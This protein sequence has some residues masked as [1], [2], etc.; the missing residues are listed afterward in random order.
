[1]LAGVL[2]DV[3]QL[4]PARSAAE[5]AVRAA[6]D[7]SAHI[8][9]LDVLI[10]VLLML[11]ELGAARARLE[12]LRQAPGP[13]AALAVTFR[14]ARL[15]RVDGALEQAIARLEAVLEGLPATDRRFA[16]PRAA[17]WQDI[18]EFHLLAGRLG[19]AHSA[20]DAAVRAWSRSRRRP[21]AFAAEGLSVRLA[22]AQATP[23]LPE[24]LDNAVDFADQ[25]GLVLLGAELRIARARAG[26][27]LGRDAASAD[28]DHAVQVAAEAG[29]PLLEG[30]ARLWRRV[31][32]CPGD[33]DDVARTRALLAP[34]RILGLHPAIW[35]AG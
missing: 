6:A 23:V 22:L 35:S 11:G 5:D 33:A 27:S 2:Q 7:A 1:M 20:L 13:A 24:S 15:E 18:A 17:A 19:P 14:T 3:G 9:A 16:A 30:R 31:V 4:V 26:A 28:F 21:G 8:L 34:D 32:G 10:G 25:R 29:A 12:E